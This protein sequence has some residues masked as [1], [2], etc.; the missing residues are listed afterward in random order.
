MATDAR[1]RSRTTP[2]QRTLKSIRD[3]GGIA[4]VTE[5]WIAIP[6]HPAGGVRRDLFNFIDLIRLDGTVTGIQCTAAGGSTRIA[7]IKNECR[8]AAIA[9]LMA[10]ARIEVWAWRKLK[11]KVDRKSWQARVTEL[12]I[13]DFEGNS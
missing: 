8:D 5:R 10:G 3:S 2:T 1:K 9:W 6:K 11:K 13:E 12:M 4:D 7:K